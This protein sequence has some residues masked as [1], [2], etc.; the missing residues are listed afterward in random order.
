MNPLTKAT[1]GVIRRNVSKGAL[2][3]AVA[4]TLYFTGIEIPEIN[5]VGSGNFIENVDRV[6]QNKRSLRKI[7]TEDSEIIAIVE[8]CLKTT[9]I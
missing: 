4:G 8:L 2:V 6:D 3:L 5:D 1:R 7:Q 9:I